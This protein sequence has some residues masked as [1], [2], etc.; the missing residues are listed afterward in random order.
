MVFLLLIKRYLWAKIVANGH[1]PTGFERNT[2]GDTNL[3]P[4]FDEIAIDRKA[5]P[6]GTEF[7]K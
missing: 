3:A 7:S 6:D 5:I 4:K 1:N 2:I